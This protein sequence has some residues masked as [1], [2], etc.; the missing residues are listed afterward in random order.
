MG[1]D[2]YVQDV[3]SV[4]LADQ[5]QPTA[6]RMVPRTLVRAADHNETTR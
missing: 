4:D 6:A 1:L 2:T 5:C 3:A